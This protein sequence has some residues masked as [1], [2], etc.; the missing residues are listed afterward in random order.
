[1]TSVSSSDSYVLGGPPIKVIGAISVFNTSGSRTVESCHD[2]W[3]R[4]LFGVCVHARCSVTCAKMILLIYPCSTIRLFL[5]ARYSQDHFIDHR[6]L[7]GY[8]LGLIIIYCPF[9]P[10]FDWHGLHSHVGAVYPP[11]THLLPRYHVCQLRIPC[12]HVICV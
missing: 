11:R 6:L 7:L 1:M 9:V 3:T 12:V 2:L 5:K 8:V 4:Q 10:A